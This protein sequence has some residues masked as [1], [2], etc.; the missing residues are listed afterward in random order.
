MKILLA[1]PLLSPDIGGPATYAK[2]LFD[3]LPKQNITITTAY[4]GEIRHLPKIIRHIA[5]FYL[6]LKKT[7]GV[8]VV[9]ALDAVSVGLPARMAAFLSSKK[10][11]IRIAGDYAWEQGVQR[12]GVV[13]NLDDFSKQSGYGLQVSLFK[14][15]QF[16]VAITADKVI[17]PSNYFKGIV[18][19]W[20][21]PS[22]KIKVIYSVFGLPE[23][24]ITKQ[25]CRDELGVH[26]VLLLSAGRLVPWKGFGMLIELVSELKN[27]YPEVKL[28]IAG[29][30]PEQKALEALISKLNLGQ[31][32]VLL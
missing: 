10:F 12:L 5:Y 11:L 4:F 3:E 30:G 7:R 32:V 8:D 16:V 27:K 21:V 20:G 26:G 15:I 23:S 18:M 25:T 14:F 28:L 24:T 2:I 22:E 17:V 29:S 19:N 9:Y 31:Y 13:D 6:V 1:T